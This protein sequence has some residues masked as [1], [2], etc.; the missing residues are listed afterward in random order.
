MI[1]PNAIASVRWLFEKAI[2]ENS[3]SDIGASCEV[4]VSPGLGEEVEGD[5]RRH[6]VVIGISSY[7]FRIVVLFDFDSSPETL[8][9]LARCTG[10]ESGALQGQLLA[11][12]YGELVNMI[13]G[14]VKRALH[15]IFPHT[16]MSTPFVL[17]SACAKY[18]CTLNPACSLSFAVRLNDGMNF[19]MTVCLCV[20]AGTVLDFSV[21]RSEREAESSGELEFF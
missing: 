7:L 18:V 1:K 11:D 10:S 5:A 4:T 16:G 21:D 8:A 17:E 12:A 6:L 19:H 15:E 14:A 2:R 3:G 13:C 9:Y 20:A